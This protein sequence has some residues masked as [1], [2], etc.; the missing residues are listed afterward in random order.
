M[1]QP[2]RP[3]PLIHP[4]VAIHL[5]PF[6]RY[7]IVFKLPRVHVFRVKLKPPHPTLL[8]F[9]PSAGIHFA[10]LVPI[11]PLAM[12][13]V[14]LPLAG[15]LVAVGVIAVSVATRAVASPLAC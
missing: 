5:R 7:V 8:P 13:P 14:V 2:P 1:P 9:H 4:P 3:V 12:R 10:R 6:P 15:V 11:R